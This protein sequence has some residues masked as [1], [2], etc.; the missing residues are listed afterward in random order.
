MD[1]EVLIVGAGP[2]G[3]AIAA[4]ASE[5]QIEHTIV[6]RPME[7]WRRHMPQGMYLRSACDWHLDPLNVDTIE[8]FVELQGKTTKDVE[9]LSLDFYLSYVDWFQVQKQIRPLPPNR[10]LIQSNGLDF[11]RCSQSSPSL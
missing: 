1:T 6:G 2:F 5:K 4:L 9:P 10:V 3:L 7:F 11:S 8:R